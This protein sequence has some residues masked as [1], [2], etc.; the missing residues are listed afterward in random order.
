MDIFI[1]FFQA[2]IKYKKACEYFQV[3]H[4]LADIQKDYSSI[5]VSNVINKIRI[6]YKVNRKSTQIW[7]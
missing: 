7:L 4:F 5:F 3:V 6:K 2:E 1:F